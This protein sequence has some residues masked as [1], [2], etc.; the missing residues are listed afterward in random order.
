MKYLPAA[1]AL[2]LSCIPLCA[3]EELFPDGSPVPGWFRD[4]SRTPLE[5][6]GKRFVVT[7]YGV[8]KDSTLVQTEA[9]QRVI[10]LAAGQGGVVVI[11]RG[12]FLSGALHFRQGSHLW[13]EGRLKG[14][15][16]VHDFP[17]CTT[18]IE[19]QTC[20]YFPALVNIEGV[21]GF[22]LGG[23]G[24]IDGNG[25]VFW[26]EMKIRWRWNNQATNKDGQRPRLV[27][28]SESRN[29]TVQ[30]VHI[31]DS[32][33]WTCHSY[34]SDHLRFLGLCITSPTEGSV[35]GYST[36]AIGLDNCHDVLVKDCYMSVSDDA[37]VLKGGK[38]TYADKAPENGP[39]ARIIVE[40]CHF[41][42]VH[43]CLT[44]G[45][46]SIEDRNVVLRRSHSDAAGAILHLKLRP[47]T[48]QHYEYVSV[49][50]MTGA[51]RTVLRLKPWTQYYHMEERKN[52]PLSRCNN[53]SLKRVDVESAQPLEVELS[54]QYRLEDITWDGRDLLQELRGSL[55]AK[56]TAAP[57]TPMWSPEEQRAAEK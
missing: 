10:D 1:L 55:T 49:E 18:R 11:P 12:T 54:S 25:Y 41:G 42:R 4:S 50:D 35:V 17:L 7:D 33:F 53:I 28:I 46:E 51:A 43:S 45:S 21:D 20:T 38:G 56:S 3:Q 57:G 24:T 26:E 29:V 47:D 31:K 30:D 40:D 5:S 15:D 36:D 44:L 8:K 2:L 37:V 23:N 14:S 6:L 22:V 9:I 52:M 48:P 19:G 13:V 34:R 39:N 27:H 16:R 32:P